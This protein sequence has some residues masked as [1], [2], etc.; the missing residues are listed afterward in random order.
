MARFVEIEWD[1]W[2]GQTLEKGKGNWKEIKKV[3]K[4]ERERASWLEHFEEIR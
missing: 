2:K 3:R 4:W 1:S